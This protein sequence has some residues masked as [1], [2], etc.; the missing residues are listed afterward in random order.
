MTKNGKE[1][2]DRN[3]DEEQPNDQKTK[4]RDVEKACWKYQWC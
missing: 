1:Q 4:Y 2:K 3:V